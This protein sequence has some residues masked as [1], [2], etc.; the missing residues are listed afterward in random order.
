M[1]LHQL[2]YLVAIA[3]AGSFTAAAEQLHVA[4]SGLSAQVAKLER[5]LGCRLLERVPRGVR[6]TSAG[7]GILPLAR[8]AL[9][10]V[11][12]VAQ[13]GHEHAGLL[14]GEVRAG[15]VRGGVMTS[16]LDPL[17]TFRAE[18][19]A[20][21]VRLVEGDSDDLAREVAEARLDLALVGYAG[22]GPPGLDVRTLVSEE[23]VAVV[24]ADHPLVR[25]RAR[26]PRLVDLAEEPLLL[27]ARGTGGR[28]A[29][30]VCLR[31]V[32][33][34]PEVAVESSDPAVLVELARRSLGV[35]LLSRSPATALG[36]T[37]VQVLALGD[38]EEPARLGLVTRPG[39]L[40][41]AAREL[42]ARWAAGFAGT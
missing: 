27:L 3:D 10:A 13:A 1:E 40:A 17:T 41:P 5:E 20:V 22:D 38:A 36:H 33:V 30:D 32:G 8:Q 7:S 29:A 28:A 18:H 37:G 2:R 34:T 39:A 9:A 23:L 11:D 4:Q 31:R 35:A 21:T 25:R 12:A 26:R 42:H 6:P 15:L 16:V 24:A 19:P 14:R